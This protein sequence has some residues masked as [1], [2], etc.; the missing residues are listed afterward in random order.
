[1]QGFD[2]LALE[3]L[4]AGYHLVF[5]VEIECAHHG[6][7]RG[8][9][10]WDGQTLCCPRCQEAVQASLL[11]RGVTKDPAFPWRCVSPALPAGYKTDDR[12]GPPAMQRGERV[13]SRK[14]CDK[15]FA[16]ARRE[17]AGVG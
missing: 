4:E 16:R 9:A 11:A 13:S 17:L 2:E 8:T 3:L 15:F 14:R 12:P 6:A 10:A 7:F 5:W 1:M